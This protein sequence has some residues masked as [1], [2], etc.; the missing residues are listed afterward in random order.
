MS[1]TAYLLALT[2]VALAG[3]V[4][5]TL[6]G[7]HRAARAE[8]TGIQGLRAPRALSLRAPNWRAVPVAAQQGDPKPN[9][10]ANAR[11]S[12]Y[13][14]TVDAYKEA[15]DEPQHRRGTGVMAT[16]TGYVFAPLFVVNDA[17]FVIVNFGPEHR[18]PARIIAQD[19][20][21]MLAVLRASFPPK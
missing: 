11:L 18:S 19:P 9:E 5:M 4:G 17:D 14:V 1:R 13:V 15:D 16:R 8:E 12:G 6:A 3:V 20:H 2:Q 7:G 10:E 21:S